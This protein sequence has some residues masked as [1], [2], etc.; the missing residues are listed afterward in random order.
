MLTRL[1]YGGHWKILTELYFQIMVYFE[2][3]VHVPTLECVVPDLDRIARIEQMAIDNVETKQAIVHMNSLV[4]AILLNR[5]SYL[6][7]FKSMPKDD[8][9]R[10]EESMR[11]SGIA[12]ALANSNRVS[13]PRKHF[14][15]FRWNTYCKGQELKTELETL[16]KDYDMLYKDHSTVRKEANK[17]Q[18]KLDTLEDEYAK[19][20]EQY[21][22]KEEEFDHMVA[23]MQHL[24]DKLQVTSL[25][26]GSVN[27][28]ATQRKEELRELKKRLAEKDALISQQE[29]ERKKDQEKADN[30]EKMYQEKLTEKLSLQKELKGWEKDKFD[31]TN[32]Q[33]K[34]ENEREQAVV[35]TKRLKLLH[36][37]E[38]DQLKQTTTKE[39]E[40]LC[41][42]LEDGKAKLE[43]AL[44]DSSD[45]LVLLNSKEVEIQ[46]LEEQ[47]A[48]KSFENDSGTSASTLAEPAFLDLQLQLS[49]LSQQVTELEE[50]QCQYT[51]LICALNGVATRLRHRLR[52]VHA[53]VILL[54]KHELK[55]R[56]SEF[57]M[58]TLRAE[59]KE[60]TQSLTD[61]I[62]NFASMANDENSLSVT[63]LIIVISILASNIFNFQQRLKQLRRCI[64]SLNHHLD[65]SQV[66]Y[67][68]LKSK[69]E[70]LTQ[71]TLRAEEKAW[72]SKHQYE[73]QLKSLQVGNDLL[74]SRIIVLRERYS[75]AQD[76]LKR[77][78]L[79]SRNDRR[80][81]DMVQNEAEKNETNL[82]RDITLLKQELKI[83]DTITKKYNKA[84]HEIQVLK[85]H[86]ERYRFNEEERDTNDLTVLAAVHAMGMHEGQKRL[87]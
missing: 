28:N 75:G 66:I 31:V 67:Q 30:F 4:L 9:A 83:L 46:Q 59:H 48:A 20:Q 54:E 86:L 24:D 71:V 73:V 34:L 56:S 6:E 58:Q 79:Q 53:H 33:S 84:Q 68:K 39:K 37:K 65:T 23:S 61:Q 25:A 38:L 29:E 8:A 62:A 10:L 16:R 81:L 13:E 47:L 57:A 72:E 15:N 55:Y 51:L 7:V 42:Q 74:E 76:A 11:N 26:L 44:K 63:P 69:N 21:E 45:H 40:E 36:D 1:S 17:C 82:N 64:R 49:E 32:I 5:A 41:L 18:K 60:T 50:T 27:S 14:Y 87:S 52:V 43:Q 2:N 70:E 78:R 80:T 85:S 19:I 35:N 22:K 12:Q 77:M 3:V